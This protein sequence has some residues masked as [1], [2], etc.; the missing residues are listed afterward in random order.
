MGV[1]CG[2]RCGGRLPALLRELLP[3][4]LYMALERVEGRFE[5]VH[6]RVGRCASV[7]IGAENRLV[8]FC[9]TEEQMR[10]T[11]L[12]VCDGSLYARR[13]DISRGFVCLPG[14]VRVGVCG[15]ASVGE[16]G[17]VL[18]VRNVRALC[19]RLPHVGHEC[20]GALAA[21]L[22]LL[23]PLGALLYSPPG[24]GKTTL[25]RGLT[26]CFAGGESPLRAALI[27]CRGEV[28][29]GGFGERLCLSVL[30]GYP[31]GRAIEI[32]TRTLN[33]QVILCDE[34]G[35]EQE[36]AALLGAANAGV[37]VI[38]TAH[39][40]TLPQLLRRPAFARLHTAAVFGAYVGI[41]RAA[42]GEFFYDMVP[43]KDAAGGGI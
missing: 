7:S 12:R 19:L 14:G 10:E 22:R 23:F 6:L 39:A 34:I 13:E 29:D 31:M 5:E 16:D 17:Q 8:D 28:D 18:G 33:A 32:A 26:T 30:S 25:L 24:V 35:N 43:W 27:D 36:S 20:G 37:P 21:R 11:L 41:R 15:E 38:A 9:M 3:P 2:Q 1:R 4:A 42:A 40:A